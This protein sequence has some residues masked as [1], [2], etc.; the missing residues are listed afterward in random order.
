V[1]H[2]DR[3]VVTFSYMAGRVIETHVSAIKELRDQLEEYKLSSIECQG[4]NVYFTV[5]PIGPMGAQKFVLRLQPQ[6]PSAAGTLAFA[7]EP[8]GNEVVNLD[9]INDI[10]GRGCTV[11]SALAQLGKALKID[12]GWAQ[13][14]A[15]VENER[16]VIEISDDDEIFISDEYHGGIQE[17][18]D[19]S[20][21]Y[22]E[23]VNI[24]KQ[25]VHMECSRK[26]SE[27]IPPQKNPMRKREAAFK[28]LAEEFREFY[29]STDRNLLVEHCG[30][31]FRWRV[32]MGGF[33]NQSLLDSDLI[34]LGETKGVSVVEFEIKFESLYPHY[35]PSVRLI[36]PRFKNRVFELV[37]SHP[38]LQRRN[39]NV[40]WRA[41]NVINLVR[42]ILQMKGRVEFDAQDQ[43]YFEVE[44]LL[45]R[46]HSLT[47]C[48][49][50][51]QSTDPV[52]VYSE[53]FKIHREPETH[54]DDVE[55]KTDKEE[56]QASKRVKTHNGNDDKKD[57][58]VWG[59]GTGYGDGYG[60]GDSYIIDTYKDDFVD[61]IAEILGGG[62]VRQEMLNAWT[63]DLQADMLLD[64]IEKL[65]KE[66]DH[67]FSGE[68]GNQ[69][70]R[71]MIYSALEDSCLLPY[72]HQFLS[73]TSISDLFAGAQQVKLSK[74]VVCCIQ[75]LLKVMPILWTPIKRQ[76][77]VEVS[78]AIVNKFLDLS[79]HISTYLCVVLHSSDVAP[80]LTAQEQEEEQSVAQLFL[81]VANEISSFDKE[82]G[83]CEEKNTENGDGTN[84]EALYVSKLAQYKLQIMPGIAA[85][86]HYLQQSKDEPHQSTSKRAKK[87]AAHLVDLQS[88]LPI[89][90]SSSIF[91]VADEQQTILWK[92]IIIGP[93]DTP[94]EG[95]AF[96]F[97]IY[98]D[99]NYP[100]EPPKVNFRTTGRGSVRFN[101]NLYEC[102]KV[103]LSLL[104][105]WRGGPGE[106]WTSDIST[107][108]Q[109]LTSIQALI[110]VEQPY[111]NEPGY[112]RDFA[113]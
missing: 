59:A 28:L 61:L 4:F 76:E 53:E 97:D 110:F 38:L 63:K 16:E 78:E 50:L 65:T 33:H 98:F 104:K 31:I 89:N 45:A 40:G 105:T 113:D 15:V 108:M 87:V 106:M 99:H 67:Q 12:L 43:H 47:G 58:L 72:L 21:K 60:G 3:K 83:S 22:E 8:N 62:G 14:A 66:I 71:P 35:P 74:A 9:H 24:E 95:G 88:Y 82:L 109:V 13:E 39:W 90:T 103:C 86:H 34:Q 84:E 57:K 96:L 112:A 32:T 20:E 2:R 10:I 19:W 77:G 69:K 30:G 44:Y 37:V 85:N 81:K 42:Q 29:M 51:K 1:Y 68:E 36:S 75:S 55:E 48:P 111:Y 79:K 26:P 91:V 80:A 56:V 93:K 64:I 6:Y 94:Y 11:G 102:G 107:V 27:T 7:G 100:K 92:A 54:A 25:T 52:H 73:A 46:L 17:V 23:L 18:R 41:K 49:C 101:P 5:N 70:R